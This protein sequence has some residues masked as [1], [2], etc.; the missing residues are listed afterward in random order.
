VQLERR[1]AE[2][3]RPVV[4]DGLVGKRRIG[5][6]QYGQ[7]IPDALM[8]DDRRTGV[9]ERLTPGDVIEMMVAV[10]QV[11]DRLIRDLP[12]LFDIDLRRFAARVTDRVGRMTPAGV[13]MN[14]DCAL[15]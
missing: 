9:L 15:A 13:T 6:V 7:P 8:R 10:N 5:V 2:A 12:D 3:D 4:S 14:I 11:T 1:A